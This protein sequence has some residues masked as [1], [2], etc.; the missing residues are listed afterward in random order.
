MLC[1]ARCA[2]VVWLLVL[3]QAA[4]AAV[5]CPSGTARVSKV[6]CPPAP[7]CPTPFP[8]C[9]EQAA[10]QAN[11][12]VPLPPPACSAADVPVYRGGKWQCA[13]S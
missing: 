3:S 13:R 12:K 8:V 4:L 10:L 11:K 5:S 7:S 2:A 6:P 1:I 9:V